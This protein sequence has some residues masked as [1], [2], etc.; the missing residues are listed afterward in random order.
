M[1]KEDELSDDESQEPARILFL[2]K[3]LLGA[4]EEG[5][6]QTAELHGQNELGGGAT[7]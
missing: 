5:T 7:A 6:E 4:I 3:A 1:Q 2:L